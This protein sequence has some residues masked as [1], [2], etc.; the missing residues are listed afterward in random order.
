MARLAPLPWRVPSRARPRRPGSRNHHLAA[1]VVVGGLAN[2]AGQI[3]SLAAC[4]AI[5]ATCAKS[6]PMIAAIAPSPTGTAPCMAAPRMRSSRAASSM[7]QR[8]GGAERRI[9]AER[10]A[11]DERR[12]ARDDRA[13]LRSRARATPPGSPPSAPAARWRSASAPP[14]AP[15]T[16]VAKASGRARIDAR[17][18]ARAAGNASPSAL[19]MPTACEPCPGNTK[20]VFIPF[21]YPRILSARAE[22]RAGAGCQGRA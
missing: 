22:T 13:R 2:R 20:A 18:D 5:A 9:F 14:P 10:M 6:R 19:P 17:E 11:G 4:A 15:R 21:P 3:S 8:A 1:A 7:R 12:V 16:S